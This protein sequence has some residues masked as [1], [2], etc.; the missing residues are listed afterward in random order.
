MTVGAPAQTFMLPPF[1]TVPDP[2]P[3]GQPGDV[4]KTEDQNVP[5]LHGTVRRVM[6]HSRS[7]MGTDIAVTGL[8]LV[9]SGS[10]PAGGF[11]VVTW[12][13]GTTGIADMCAPSLGA[14]DVADFLPRSIGFTT[15]SGRNMAQT[16]RAVLKGLGMFGAP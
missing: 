6:Y 13:H 11:P 14:S 2:L 15:A 10:P 4:I 12:A 9:P 8:I 5:G 7:V 1:Y 16:F 3:A